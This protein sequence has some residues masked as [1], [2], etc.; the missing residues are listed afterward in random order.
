MK[1]PQSSLPSPEELI[2][3]DA[4]LH[5]R[6]FG[7]IKN[8]KGQ[9]VR[10]SPNVMQLSMLRHYRQQ[11][12]KGEPTMLVNLKP[13]QRGSSTISTYLGYFHSQRY[14]NLEGVMAGH[15][16]GASIN[17]MELYRRYAL[18]DEFAWRPGQ[19]NVAD[20]GNL[21]ED[22]TLSN[23]SHVGMLTAGSTT[24]GRSGTTQFATLTE[25][26]FWERSD[27]SKAD[28][29]LAFI[30]SCYLDGPETLVIME[31]TP[32]GASGYFYRSCMDAL[33]GKGRWFFTFTPWFD[34]PECNIPFAHED[35]KC[36]FEESLTEDEKEEV[37]RFGVNLEQLNWRRDTVSTMCQGDV[38]KFRQEY[39][40]DPIECFLL[41]ARPRFNMVI[42]DNLI[43]DAMKAKVGTMTLQDNGKASFLPDRGGNWSV[44]EEPRDGLSY[45]ISVDTSTGEDQQTQNQLAPDPDYHSVQVWRAGYFDQDDVWHKHRLV[46]L[47]H[48]RI[49]LTL[50]AEEVAAVSA[51]YGDPLVVPE[52]NNS[53]LALV[54][55]L[56]E[57]YDV[58]LYQRKRV[59]D[60][61]GMVERHYGWMTDRNTRKTIIDNLAAAVLNEDLDI[62][63]KGVL[64]QFKTFVINSKGKPEASPGTHDDHV[65][66]AAI[67]LYNMDGASMFR[68]QRR[69]NLSARQLTKERPTSSPDGFLNQ[70]LSKVAQFNSR[71]RAG[72]RIRRL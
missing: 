12:L 60:T 4:E 11:Q 26:A 57:L 39:P 46:A 42:V 72:K 40:S 49:D 13:R 27:S 67:A 54:K 66:A 43:K 34:F 63:D 52:V 64:E 17:M 61:N 16:K 15:I 9:L 36:E 33:R 71:R 1:T 31:S 47:H 35:E 62:P 58:R 32:N 22:I 23:G 56:H 65:L 3:A 10:P 69:N 48:S 37:Q 5:L 41:S 24:M 19:P 2:R 18:N 38:Q 55:F 53:G 20:G 28:P 6:T 25:V 14:S 51:L 45:L 59:N 44:F 70:P 29:A 21:N 30:N 50:L 7:V 68:V 8:K